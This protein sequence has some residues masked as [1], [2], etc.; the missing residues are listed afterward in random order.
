MTRN[1]GGLYQVS[2][3]RYIVVVKVPGSPTRLVRKCYPCS[4]SPTGWYTEGE[5][6]YIPAKNDDEAAQKWVDGERGSDE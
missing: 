4:D 5:P 6:R 1:N 3:S 2:G